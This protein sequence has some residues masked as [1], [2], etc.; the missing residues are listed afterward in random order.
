MSTDGER[1]GA[2][3]AAGRPRVKICGITRE[4]D[5][6]AAARAG[7]DAVGLISRVDVDTPRE[8]APGRAA[9]LADAAP[10]FVAP[11]LVTMAPTVD[12][13]ADLADRTGPDAVQVHADLSP[14]ELRDLGSRVRADVI[15]A[16][17][18]GDPAA[19][20]AHDG[21]ADA[22]LVDSLSDGGAG[23]TGETHDW[24]QTA[25]AVAEVETP[26]I[27]AGGLT[28]DNVAPAVETVAPYGVDVASGVE[29]EGGVKDHDAVAAFVDRARSAGDPG[30]IGRD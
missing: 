16:V 8:I 28:P 30:G 15:R 4:R 10:P 11:V 6:A 9:D 20:R 22:L 2:S 13:L 25:A 18:A 26:V 19:V 3:A 5:L 27:L 24:E 29:R 7:A 17:D 14:G 12:A 23:G 21:A 1:T